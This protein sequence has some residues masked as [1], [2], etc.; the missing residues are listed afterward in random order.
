VRR[1]IRAD[2][3][4]EWYVLNGH[5]R[6]AVKGTFKTR[7]AAEVRRRKSQA[8]HDQKHAA[9]MQKLARRSQL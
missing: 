5:T 1:Q 4:S 2:G 9:A 3:S 7:A 8:E 6:R